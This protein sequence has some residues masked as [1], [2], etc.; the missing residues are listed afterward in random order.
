MGNITLAIKPTIKNT[1]MKKNEK[2]IKR[3]S[4]TTIQLHENFGQLISTYQSNVDPSVSKAFVRLDGENYYL[5]KVS[6]I[7]P[8]G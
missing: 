6:K 7:E 5:V 4:S 2:V 8:K 3:V 1:V